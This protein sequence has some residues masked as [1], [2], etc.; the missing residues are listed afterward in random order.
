MK[1]LNILIVD[2]E[3]R[4]RTLL[5]ECID[6]QSYGLNIQ[7]EAS[8]AFEAMDI[9]RDNTPDIMFVDI[10]MPFMNGLELSKRVLTSYP[11]IKIVILTGYGEFSY[12]K[13]SVSL[14]VFE[15]LEKPIQPEIIK[16]TA[17]KLYTA[18]TEERTF[19]AE[20]STFKKQIIEQ[21]NLYREKFLNGLLSN[22]PDNILRSQ[23]ESVDLIL[24]NSHFQV[25]VIE[26]AEN[27]NVPPEEMF[28][29]KI[30]IQ[31][32]TDE[33]FTNME[34][35]YIFRDNMER[36]TI[37]SNNIDI[38]LP[39]KL[40]PLLNSLKQT[41]DITL[42]IGI[43]NE[44]RTDEGIKN[45]YTEACKSLSYC[46]II[47]W[48]TV[49]W[50]GEIENSSSE[51][52][53]G[54][55]ENA[56]SLI[57]AIKSGM[58]DKSYQ[59]INDIF[60]ISPPKNRDVLSVIRGISAGVMAI[61]L[62]IMAETDITDESI[63]LEDEHPFQMIF[64]YTT[65]DELK[66]Y[67]LNINR[68]IHSSLNSKS[69][70]KKQDLINQIQDYMSQNLTEL[71]LSQGSVAEKFTMNPSYLSRF[72][73]KKTGQTFVEYLTELRINK[74]K[75]YLKSSNLKAYEIANK[76]GIQ[77]PQYF[78]VLFKKNTGFSISEYRKNIKN[79]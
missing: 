12:A 7:N 62:Q 51:L 15:F 39:T 32:Q 26:I 23:F 75:L 35:L 49:I 42:V 52:W 33:Y 38:N 71:E 24:T 9:I 6:W 46:A 19:R 76:I 48:D 65:L 63:F 66:K 36:T 58:N 20:Y 30:G 59:I 21:K 79:M 17:N 25:A 5:R 54:I 68:R 29:K 2:D 55:S 22:T 73:K 74:S 14:G 8:G 44:Y 56:D 72:F 47:G 40:E 28:L 16:S 34:G 45:S 3:P 69:L 31:T 61:F 64:S 53:P 70:N 13:E 41:L 10:N 4:T 57:F 67:L 11:F 1:K 43:G 27:I 37:L 50:Y 78:S 77:D 18:I 60:N